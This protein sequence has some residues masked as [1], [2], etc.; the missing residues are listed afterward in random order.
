MRWRIA[1]EVQDGKGL[2]G[3]RFS[4]GLFLEKLLLKLYIYLCCMY[5]YII[6]YIFYIISNIS[7]ELTRK[8]YI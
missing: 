4:E 5:V 6:Y 3:K 1:K 7:N 2:Y 8:L